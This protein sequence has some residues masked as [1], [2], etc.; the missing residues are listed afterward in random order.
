MRVVT[1]RALVLHVRRVDRDAAGA[2]LRAVV[3]VPEGARGAAEAERGDVGERGRER[4]L[5]VVDVADGAD[6]DVD[7]LRDHGAPSF[8]SGAAQLD[9]EHTGAPRRGA[10]LFLV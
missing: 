8:L 3:D 5:A 9:D 2:R 4:G 10:P 6:V 7:L 1:T